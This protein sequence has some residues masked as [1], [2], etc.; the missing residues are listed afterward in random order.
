MY[1]LDE[2]RGVQ[3]PSSEI[4]KTGSF[5]Y[6]LS[7]FRSGEYKIKSGERIRVNMTSDT[8]IDEADEWRDDMWGIIKKRSDV[9]FWLLTKRPERILDHLPSDWGDGYENVSLNITCENQE[10]FDNRIDIFLNIPAKHKGLCLAP[11]LSDIDISRALMSGQIEEVSVGGENYNNPRPIE[12]KWVEHIA[13]TCRQYKINFCWY[14]TG[15][16]LIL[17]NKEYYMPEKGRQAIEAYFAGLNQKYYDIDFKLKDSEGNLIP[18]S[19]YYEP[20]FNT[21]HCMFCSNQ[22]ICNGCSRCGNCGGNENLVTRLEFIAMQNSV[23]QQMGRTD[24]IKYN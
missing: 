13:D 3:T 17:N 23:V 1:A 18:K 14:E 2:K 9:I 19:D 4:H 21:N 20:L 10:M 8:F 5:K 6:P 11:L 24:L 16:R 15:T 22:Q 7:K 12:A